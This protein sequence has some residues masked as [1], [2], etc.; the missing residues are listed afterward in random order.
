[1]HMLA[2]YIYTG[3]AAHHVKTIINWHIFYIHI[4]NNFVDIILW[5]YESVWI[6][7]YQGRWILCLE[8][9]LNSVLIIYFIKMK[10]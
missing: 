2:K 4:L 6:L 5:R 1:M 3:N 10:R 8:H 7:E 9:I